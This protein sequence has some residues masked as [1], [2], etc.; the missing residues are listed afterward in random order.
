[1]APG[2]FHESTPYGPKTF[3]NSGSNSQIFEFQSCSAGYQTQRNTKKISDRGLFKHESL[4]S[5]VYTCSRFSKSVLLKRMASSQNFFI[6]FCRVLICQRGL[7]PHRTKSCG[8]SDPAEQDPA[9]YQTPQNYILW[10]IRPCQTM[11]ELCTFYCIHLFCGVGYPAEQCPMGSD[12]PLNKVLRG[13]RP[14]GTKSYGVSN[15]SEQHSKTNIS[16][17]LKK[18][19]KIF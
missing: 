10:C 4:G 2:F 7:I 19:S 16:A 9:G 12:T 11:A 14:R 6:W 1:L 18:N 5:V 3:L 8:V 13:I 17:N 15:P